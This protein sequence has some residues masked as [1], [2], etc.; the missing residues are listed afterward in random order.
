[1]NDETIKTT[2]Q[3]CADT[4]YGVHSTSGQCMYNT[5]NSCQLC[6]WLVISGGKMLDKTIFP[7]NNNNKIKK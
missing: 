3:T 1:M 7:S 5:M 2:T 6:S 4:G